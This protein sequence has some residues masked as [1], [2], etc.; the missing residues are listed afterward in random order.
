MAE[1]KKAMRELHQCWE[2]EEMIRARFR[3]HGSLLLWGN[4]KILGVPCMANVAMNCKVLIVFQD[5]FC[6]MQD[7]PKSPHVGFIRAQAGPRCG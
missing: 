1:E 6:P 4:D 2:N 5:F 7:G 3:E